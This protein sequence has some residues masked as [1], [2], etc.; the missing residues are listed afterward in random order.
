MRQLVVERNKGNPFPHL[1]PSF[2][3][4]SKHVIAAAPVRVLTLF[5][6][7]SHLCLSVMSVQQ[8]L[9]DGVDPCA[10]DDKGR[11]ALHFASCNGNDRIGE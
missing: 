11:T 8:L 1:F 4:L 9:E 2:P 7:S 3:S 10:A 5:T 6:L